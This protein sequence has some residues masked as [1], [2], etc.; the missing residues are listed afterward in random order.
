MMKKLGFL[1]AGLIGLVLLSPMF[2]YWWGLSNIEELPQPS[3]INL[4]SEQ[5][6]NIWST[7]KEVGTPRVEEITPYGYIAHFY[8]N[9]THGVNAQICM[10]RYPGLRISAFAVRRHIAEKV[11]GKG[12]TVWQFTWAAYSIWVTRNWDIH[13][14]LATYHETY[15]T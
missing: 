12:N 9:I 10:S 13:Q 3:R 4:T 1:A 5:E 15:N 8:C 7:E 14:I 2:L 6:L 11:R